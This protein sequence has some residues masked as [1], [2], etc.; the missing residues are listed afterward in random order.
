MGSEKKHFNNHVDY[1]VLFFTYFFKCFKLDIF[2]LN[3]NQIFKEATI[4]I[5]NSFT[6]TTRELD[7]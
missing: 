7:G 5:K 2:N 4:K 1:F 3:Y 6:S